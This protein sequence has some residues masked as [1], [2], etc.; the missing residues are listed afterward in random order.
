VVVVFG[1]NILAFLYCQFKS[2]NSYI[3]VFWG[4]TFVSPLVALIIQFSVNGMT[5]YARVWLNFVLVTIWG[6]RLAYH[7]GIRH[8]KEDYRYVDMRT[9]WM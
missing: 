6:V 8:T 1:G 9:R 7:I 2:D 5:I 3:D 4:L